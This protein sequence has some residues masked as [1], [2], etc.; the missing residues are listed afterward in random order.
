VP[1]EEAVTLPESGGEEAVTLPA[2]PAPKV[3]LTDLPHVSPSTTIESAAQNALIDRVNALK[4]LDGLLIQSGTTATTTDAN[5][6]V[7]I[8]FPIPY[9]A[10]PVLMVALTFD[11]SALYAVPPDLGG[12]GATPTAAR[13]IV[14]NRSDGSIRGNTLVRI[15]W[16]A[17]GSAA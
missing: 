6:E 14:R 10:A 3:G 7:V 5:G 15:D 13:V 16:I 9:V 4:H 17:V 11:A 2:E 1:D 8:T 12:A